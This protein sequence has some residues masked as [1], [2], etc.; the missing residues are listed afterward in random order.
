LR[1]REFLKKVLPA[2]AID[3]Y[4]RRRLLRRY[5]RAL[6]EELLARRM[7]EGGIGEDG[8]ATDLAERPLW[9]AIE[10]TELLLEQLHRQIESLG[11]R[12]GSELRDLRAEVV[13]LAS[14]V[15]TLQASILALTSKASEEF[16]V[17]SAPD[18]P[19][20]EI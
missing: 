1:F 9:Q 20:A 12:H 11:A 10:R 16:P 19:Q 18:P 17:E 7:R 15:E 5:H 2:T 6:G 13:T 8:T 4:R 14:A 3:Q